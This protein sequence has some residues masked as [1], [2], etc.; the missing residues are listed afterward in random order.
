MPSNATYSLP[1]TEL[2]QSLRAVEP[3]LRLVPPRILRRIIKRDR[4]LPGIG[5]RVPHRKSYVI[6]RDRLLVLAEPE[7]LGLRFER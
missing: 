4:H 1:L 6:S 3:A 5:L 7:E 2:E